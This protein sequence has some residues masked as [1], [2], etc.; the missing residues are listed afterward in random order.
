MIGKPTYFW[1]K[2]TK[3]Q[4]DSVITWHPLLDHCADVA[5]C[6]QA[7]LDQTIIRKRI[8]AC[9]GIEDFNAIHQARLCVLAALHDVGK[10]NIGFQNKAL[11]NPPFIA[12][13][14]SET[15]WLFDSGSQVRAEFLKTLRLLEIMCWADQDTLPRLLLAAICHHG[16]PISCQGG[17]ANTTLWKLSATLNPFHGISNL[18]DK[19]R[20]WF[21]I[22]FSSNEGFP[23][24][25]K[26]EL[27]HAFSGLVMLADWLA[28]DEHFFPFSYDTNADRFAFAQNNAKLVCENMFLNP[29]RAVD[30]LGQKLAGFENIFGFSPR[31]VQISAEEIKMPENGSVIII[32]SET[33]SGKTE[34]AFRYFLRLFHA[35]KV[36]GMYFAL[37]TRTATTQIHSRI[38]KYV[39]NAFGEN[40]PPVTLAVPGYLQTDE[41]KGERLAP[42][43]VLWNDNDKERF[44]YRGWAAEH[45]KRY[46]AGSIVIGTIDQVL[47]SALT[48]SHAH[49]RA[50]A[51]FRHLLVVDEVHSSD[52][53]MRRILSEV[54]QRHTG[55]GGHALLMSATLGSG[56]R[57]KLLNTSEYISL[58]EAVKLPYPLLSDN[59]CKAMQK[60]VPYS[61]K[62]KIVTVELKSLMSD[63]LGIANIGL[64]AVKAG[65]KTVILRNTV[66]GAIDVQKIIE[67]MAADETCLL[68][69]CNNVSALHHFRFSKE[70]RETLDNALEGI[71]GKTRSSGGRVVVA[72]QTIQQSLDLDADLMI[73]DLCPID[74]LLQR[75]GRL[76][77]HDRK[78]EERPF[79]FRSAKVIVLVPDE[80]DLTKF[81]HP[82]GNAP[83]PHGIGTV[84]PDLRILESTW[85]LLEKN[86]QFEI[87]LMNRQLVEMA[88]HEEII[89][90]V[91][92]SDIWRKHSNIMEGIIHAQSQSA[93]LNL[94]E[95]D[96][97][98][99][100]YSFSDIHPKIKSRLGEGDRLADFEREIK[101]PFGKTFRYL[102][103]PSHWS[104][105][106]EEDEKPKIFKEDD[107]GIVF[108]IGGR[109]FIYDHW[110]LRTF[111]DNIPVE[112]DD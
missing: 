63:E 39:K 69:T 88:L 104:H 65:A 46:L 91:V 80:R 56:M 4:T 38:T 70:D 76:H 13:H 89:K 11:T 87:P 19:V 64:N 82:N 29:I 101:S 105:G 74:V 86:G 33:G 15:V 45:P 66:N 37:P 24:P 20:S 26:P 103:I 83:G 14:V 5:A 92:D 108:E 35:R 67:K 112:N 81:I 27:Q 34:A 44:R 57:Q 16:R 78:P 106:I 54:I 102:T 52:P 10:F 93:V 79:G 97:E 31:G 51:L 21:P 110:G 107:A 43:D 3:D 6:T 41:I 90:K 32:E 109:R 18:S 77:R 8:A 59:S 60:E 49:M 25:G 99:G 84:Y 58:D 72:T 55:A 36:D 7:L 30:A 85:R 28:S 68:F 9:G 95:W 48:V 73:T 75:I 71:Y 50:T 42:F 96:K 2:I 23:L 22:A 62:Q 12:G 53:Y 61:C 40:A 94:V 111:E 47:L 100:E 1:G 98:F 17:N